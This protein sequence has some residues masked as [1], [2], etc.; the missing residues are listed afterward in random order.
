MNITKRPAW[1]FYQGLRR[2]TG[3]NLFN[4][5]GNSYNFI[6]F[7]SYLYML[8]K[9]KGPF[10]SNERTNERTNDTQQTTPFIYIEI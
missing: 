10:I 4:K 3:L 9:N 2:K 5:K 8:N 6:S 1:S 7:N